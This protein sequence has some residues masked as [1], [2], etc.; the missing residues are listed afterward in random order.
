MGDFFETFSE[1]EK[2]IETYIKLLGSIEARKTIIELRRETAES[3][4]LILK[5]NFFLILYNLIESS[6]RSG[7][8]VIYD[9][10]ISKNI[11]AD[12]CSDEMRQMWVK[13]KF[14]KIPAA[15]SNQDTYFRFTQDISTKIINKEALDLS[16]RDLPISGNLD[17][18]KIR[19]LCQEH[20]IKLSLH[21]RSFGGG[22]L[23][24]VK[25]KRN[26]LAHGHVSFDECGRE[27]TVADLTRISKQ[28]LTFVRSFLNSLM[29]AHRKSLF[30]KK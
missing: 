14:K 28:V 5:A 30:L 11:S 15:S 19:K 3:N 27:Y 16:S 24:T 13:Q 29:K 20:G 18:S 10:L 4:F 8:Q 6:V 23:E 9:D 7:F 21:Y 12:Q 26:N 25:T 1:R 2:S 22:E 17:A